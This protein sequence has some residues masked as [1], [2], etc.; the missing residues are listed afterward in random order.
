MQKSGFFSDIS[1]TLTGE[2]ASVHRD[3]LTIHLLRFV[4]LAADE[5]CWNDEYIGNDN[6]KCFIAHIVDYR[7][8]YRNEGK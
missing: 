8:L 4:T 5:Q 3:A 2:A 6:N 1:T 7:M